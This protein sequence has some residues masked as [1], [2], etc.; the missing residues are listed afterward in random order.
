QTFGGQVV[1]VRV[2]QAVPAIQIRRTGIRA[3]PEITA[4]LP[5][6]KNSRGDAPLSQATFTPIKVQSAAK[7][8]QAASGKPP[9]QSRQHDPALEPYQRRPPNKTSLVELFEITP[10]A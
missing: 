8:N 3:I 4:V 7:Q 9:P 6:P 5:V 10:P 2:R 1:P